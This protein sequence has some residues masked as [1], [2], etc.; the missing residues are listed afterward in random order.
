MF[1]GLDLGLRPDDCSDLDVGKREELC[2][3]VRAYEAIGSCEENAMMRHR[4]LE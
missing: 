3:D 2:E 1:D 4:R